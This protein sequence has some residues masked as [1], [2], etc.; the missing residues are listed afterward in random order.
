MNE[1]RIS[2][3]LQVRNAAQAWSNPVSAFNANQSGIRGP[4][5]GAVL[6]PTGGVDI[7]LS[8]LAK[9]G[10]WCMFTNLDPTN[11]VQWGILDGVSH[12]FYVVGELLP[13]EF[14]PVRLS[15]N[16]GTVY[17][18]GAG[19]GTD[20]AGVDTLHFKAINASCNVKVEAFDA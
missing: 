7:D 9:P 17:G 18:T 11:Y 4:T 13:G 15:R 8:A 5:P 6:V 20:V 2:A 3:N 16:L 10:G 19:T 14:H 12:K 1:I